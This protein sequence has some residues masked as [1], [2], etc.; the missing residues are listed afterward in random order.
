MT[1]KLRC[2]AATILTGALALGGLAMAAGPASAATAGGGHGDLQPQRFTI[3]FDE[4]LPENVG[5]LR[6]RGPIHGNGVSVDQPN[7]NT[8]TVFNLG[9]GNTVTINHTDVSG[10]QPTFYQHAPRFKFNGAVFRGCVAVLKAAGQWVIVKGTGKYRHAF[11]YGQFKFFQAFQFQRDH[12]THQ[13]DFKTDPKYFRGQVDAW[14]KATAG[15][16]H[17]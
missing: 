7:S 5:L 9:R 10:T 1:P 12:K 4:T 11:G 2:F 14:G 6:A 16:G 13:C 3:K 8:L 17:R 15:H